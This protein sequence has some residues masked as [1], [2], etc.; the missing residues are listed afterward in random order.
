MVR[1]IFH[2][3]YTEI[4][5]QWTKMLWKGRV[6]PNYFPNILKNSPEGMQNFRPE[7]NIIK[8]A[9]FVICKTVFYSKIY[10]SLIFSAYHGNAIH[11]SKESINSA[12][13][14]NLKGDL[15]L[16]SS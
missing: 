1:K 4:T 15:I 2:L 5:P 11:V 16:A 3:I 6:S 13:Y 8:E 9:N 7:P 12:Q 14:N 10:Q